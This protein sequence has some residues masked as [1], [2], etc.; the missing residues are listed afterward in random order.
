MPQEEMRPL[1][2]SVLSWKGKEWDFPSGPV[3]KTPHL[4]C[5]QFGFIP[6]WGTKILYAMQPRSLNKIRKGKELLYSSVNTRMWFFYILL[7]YQFIYL[8]NI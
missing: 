8:Q 3:V 7:S 6:C 2:M 1:R 5:R 4:H